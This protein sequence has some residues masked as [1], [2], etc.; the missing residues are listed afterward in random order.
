[1]DLGGQ[2]DENGSTEDSVNLR[3]MQMVALSP[4]A[5]QL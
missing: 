4:C 3:N 2:A 5:Q 1:M